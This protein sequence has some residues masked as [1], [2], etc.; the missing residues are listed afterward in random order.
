MIQ[1]S[2]TPFFVRGLIV[3][4]LSAIILNGTAYAQ[5]K[6][7]VTAE[8]MSSLSFH[9]AIRDA[10]RSAVEQG[11]GV[12]IHSETEVK[13]F[14]LQK[15][16][17]FS[18]TEGYLLRSDIVSKKKEDGLYLVTIQADV[19]LDKVKNDLIAL[20]ILLE[21][22]ERPKLMVLIEE[23]YSRLSFSG[24]RLAETEMV[25]LLHEKGFEL[26]D[27]DQFAAASQ[28]EQAKQALAG[29]LEAAKALGLMFGAQYILLGKAAVHSSGEALAGSGFKSMQ[30]SLQMKILQSRS[31]RIL[32]SVIT[33]GAAAHISE[34]AGATEALKK[35]AQKSVDTY[36]VDN[37]MNS[38]QDFLNNGLPLKVS[39][40]GVASYRQYKD[41]VELFESLDQVSSCKKEGWN[42]AGALLVL[43]LRFRG[44]S[45]ELADLLD[46][47][48]VGTGKLAVEDISPEKLDLSFK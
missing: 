27:R 18:R 16:K 24:M 38:F 46:Q 17:I 13:N 41:I 20:K 48:A 21:S 44:M 22:M 42:K 1:K 33:R 5:N 29:N 47:K 8:G 37:I 34:L 39:V 14:E 32:G 19:A 25:S 6:K 15:D 43:D 11:A 28:Q 10:Q 31:G 3:V 40:V 36:L 12:F 4:I 2:S 26:A 9:A 30:A 45:E 35:C 23:D 7:T